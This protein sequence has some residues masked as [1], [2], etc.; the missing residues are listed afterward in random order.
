MFI[1]PS[2][3]ISPLS[4]LPANAVS[5]EGSDRRAILYQGRVFILNEVHQGLQAAIFRCRQFLD[6]NVLAIVVDHG[7]DQP[8]SLWAEFQQVPLVGPR[9]RSTLPSPQ[10]DPATSLEALVSCFEG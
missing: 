7:R 5:P 10:S 2:H 4:T 6:N 9:S 8:A 1:L 3:Q